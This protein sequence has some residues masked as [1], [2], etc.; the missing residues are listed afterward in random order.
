MPTQIALLIYGDR[1]TSPQCGQVRRKRGNGSGV[2]QSLEALQCRRKR[3]IP[4]HI[5]GGRLEQ[6]GR[7]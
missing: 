6:L 7:E 1:T 5:A 4:H 2:R 3:G